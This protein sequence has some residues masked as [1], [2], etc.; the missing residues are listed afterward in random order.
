[1]MLGSGIGGGGARSQGNWLESSRVHPT[2]C[3]TQQ[4]TEDADQETRRPKRGKRT[5]EWKREEEEG[6]SEH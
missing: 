4:E 5:E 6:K 2:L 1:M 3:P